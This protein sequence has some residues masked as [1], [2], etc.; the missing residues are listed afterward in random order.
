MQGLSQSESRKG[1]CM[2]ALLPTSALSALGDSVK[3]KLR[4]RGERGEGGALG[5]LHLHTPA[6]P[7]Y[8]HT[9]NLGKITPTTPLTPLPPCRQS[10]LSDKAGGGW[11]ET[12]LA[13]PTR[14]L[15]PPNEV[16]ACKAFTGSQRESRKGWWLPAGVTAL[17]QRKGPRHS[18]Q[19]PLPCPPRLHVSTQPPLPASP[20]S[21]SPGSRI[22]R[23]RWSEGQLHRAVDVYQV[24]GI[25]PVSTIAGPVSRS[26]CT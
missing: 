9:P 8:R 24:L 4:A 21:P 12:P 3:C 6:C 17:S 11:P 22:A 1:W 13:T 5:N 14:V 26:S 18:P 19:N 7:S 10:R 16:A 23:R 20:L 2:H 15:R 25:H